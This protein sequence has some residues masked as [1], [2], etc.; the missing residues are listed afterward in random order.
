MPCDLDVFSL[1]VEERITDA[2]TDMPSLFALREACK[3][4][5]RRDHLVSKVLVQQLQRLVGYYVLQPHIDILLH[6]VHRWH[7]VISGHA[8]LSF[9]LRDEQFLNKEMDICVG[10]YDAM[11]LEEHLRAGISGLVLVDQYVPAYLFGYKSHPPLVRRFR[12]STGHYIR[13]LSSPLSSPACAVMH[14]PNSAYMSVVSLSFFSTLFP[15]L[16]F[17]RL[18]LTQPWFILPSCYRR[19]NQFLVAKG[20]LM[21]RH[22][23]DFMANFHFLRA[24]SETHEGTPLDGA[25]LDP[26][27]RSDN[28]SN[29][30]LVTAAADDVFWA[31]VYTAHEGLEDIFFGPVSPVH[32]G[33]NELFFIKGVSPSGSSDISLG[34]HEVMKDIAPEVASQV[35]ANPRQIEIQVEREVRV[36]FDFRLPQNHVSTIASTTSVHAPATSLTVQQEHPSEPWDCNFSVCSEF[37]HEVDSAPPAAPIT[38]YQDIF[39]CP[40]QARFFG[41]P[42]CLTDFLDDSPSSLRNLQRTHQPPFGD[43][44][45]WRFTSM[46]E[47]LCTDRCLYRDLYLRWFH[48]SGEIRLS[49][50]S[51]H[52]GRSIPQLVPLDLDLLEEMRLKPSAVGRKRDN[53][54][55]P[56]I[57][58]ANKSEGNS[59]KTVRKGQPSAWDI[60]APK[61]LYTSFLLPSSDRRPQC[62]AGHLVIFLALH[63]GQGVMYPCDFPSQPLIPPLCTD[64]VIN[65]LDYLD[66]HELL[67]IR[68]SSHL[69]DAYVAA[70]FSRRVLLLVGKMFDDYAGF[71][72]EMDITCS[73][74]GAEGALNIL[75]PVN[76]RP[77][78]PQIFTP[79]GPPWFHIVAYL[80]YYEGFQ[81]RILPRDA[82]GL[83]LNHYPL[84]FF[85]LRKGPYILDVVPSA[86]DHPA[87]PLLAQ[88]CTPLLCFV[89]AKFMSVPYPS[90]T[91]QRL[92]LINPRKLLSCRYMH[93]SLKNIAAQWENDGWTLGY[94]PAR[95]GQ[96]CPPPV[97]GA[98]P[99]SGCAGTLRHFGDRHSL[100]IIPQAM[101]QRNSGA[102]LRKDILSE[103]TVV[104]WRGGL[105]CD[106]RAL[107]RLRCASRKWLDVVHRDLRGSLIALLR[108]FVPYPYR[109]LQALDQAKGYIGGSVAV[110]FILRDSSF[111]PQ[112]LDLYVSAYDQL[113]LENHLI[114]EQDFV[115]EA[116]LGPELQVEETENGEEVEVEVVSP[117]AAAL[118]GQ[119]M[120]SVSRFQSL[121]G[122]EI[123]YIYSSGVN[124]P[125]LPIAR[126]WASHLATYASLR[127]F[128]A[129]FPKLLLERRSLLGD[130]HYGQVGNEMA[131][132]KKWAQRGFNIKLTPERWFNNALAHCAAPWYFCPTQGR[133]FQ[134]PGSL[135]ARMDPLKDVPLWSLMIWR[136]DIRPCQG[137][138]L[139]NSI[140]LGWKDVYLVGQ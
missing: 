97:V 23:D 18:A 25:P 52:H 75:Y 96:T 7:A 3:G 118:Q 94:R 39:L 27:P 124:D 102:V 76:P 17:S 129:V 47:L 137:S 54:A 133:R 90:L 80:V 126:S 115:E 121:L 9:V 135:C 86:S 70:A 30:F 37:A 117:G 8:A 127:H 91:R 55:T 120:R 111:A 74:I 51:L 20:W 14:Y 63:L 134:D 40:H 128:R 125:L 42:G 45:T 59:S 79:C 78:I 1:E 81:A 101:K 116:Y 49:V 66:I 100:N 104:F 34:D 22:V 92:A 77:F 114:Y 41:D 107:L 122:T 136:L 12:T 95:L 32:E 139:R 43:G 13:I 67:S 48:D 123:I 15:S 103:S 69:G 46:E 83:P 82:S 57:T 113:V 65:I 88:W 56:A 53:C 64:A 11:G 106:M 131:Q 140:P 132:V 73:V 85:E 31:P 44:Y 108:P 62:S 130:G 119:G 68:A 50:L 87:H 35:S 36:A 112:D 38:C 110:L 29:H 60:R 19:Q 89:G 5:R 6:A 138:C 98:R 16:T 26:P 28:P 99:H 10:S 84:Q 4:R 105:T 72:K 2:I 61:V 21:A 93:P 71:V 109:L 58:R 33:T 24:I